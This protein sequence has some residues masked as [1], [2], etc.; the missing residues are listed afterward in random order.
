MHHTGTNEEL[1]A[2]V[3]DVEKIV[4]QEGAI[5]GEYPEYEPGHYTFLAD[6][7][8]Y[9]NGDGMEHR[10]STV[11]TRQ[12]VDCGRPRS[13][14]STPSRTSSFTAG[15]SS[16]SARRVSSRSTSIA[17][18][19]PASCG[20]PKG[21]RSTTDRWRCSRAGLVDLASTASTL[22]DLVE[23][24]SSPGHLV[25]SA[26]EMSRM[27]AFIDGGRAVDARTGRSPVIS[28]YP[29]GGAIAL[30]LDLTLRDRTDGRLS[31][32]DF[33]RAMWR[34]FGKPGGAREG[35]VDR[36]YTIADAEATLASVS[37]D[38]AFARDFFA[39]YI[40]GHDVADY[41][42]L[43]ARA[44][45][46]VRKRNAG[47]RL[48]RRPAARARATARGSPISSRRPGPSIARAST[49][50]MSCGSSTASRSTGEGDL[51][52]V[53]RQHKPGD[54]VSMAF[55]DRTGKH[56]DRDGR[57]GRG[58][59]RRDRA[60]RERWRLADRGAESVPAGVAGSEVMAFPWL[61]ILDAVIGVT[62]LARSRKIRKMS[63]ESSD[64]PQQLEAGGRRRTWR[65]RSAARGRRRRR[66]EGSVR[67]RHASARARARAAR[68][69][70]SAR[71]TRARSSSCRV[72]R[73]TA[74]SA[75]CG[76]WRA[77]RWPAGSGRC[78]FRRG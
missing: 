44:G 1:D 8:P 73:A 12:P 59:A 53:L 19:C 78:S 3:K 74:R 33:M 9:A 13:D 58:S 16:A 31:L 26:E 55:A 10:N 17:R 76:C 24:V 65:P 27:A 47:R 14:C 68:G 45:F 54:S 64:Q 62:D 42:R 37:G 70:A 21:S 72:R 60:G 15:T 48:A 69:R 51:S 36:P 18:T 77:S 35:Y 41:A 57:P 67:S 61:Q 2:L 11:M 4:E 25:R 56:D 75:G 7:L 63:Q 22:T 5:F 20:W 23:A 71:R 66:A 29:F 39:R 38:R 30:A 34:T 43:L 40:Q 50:T 6:Y 32:D 52:A 46:A 28:Y 49:R